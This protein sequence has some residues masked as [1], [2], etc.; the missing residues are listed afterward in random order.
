ME[1]KQ[2]LPAAKIEQESDEE[3]DIIDLDKYVPISEGVQEWDS[4]V[5]SHL[6]DVTAYGCERKLDS[7]MKWYIESLKNEASLL[8]AHS[9]V[10]SCIIKHLYTF[11]GCLLQL[12]Y[13]YVDNYLDNMEEI[14]TFYSNLELKLLPKWS[15]GKNVKQQINQMCRKLI[16]YIKLY[17]LC[18][19]DRALHV[20]MKMKV[21]IHSNECKSFMNHLYRAFLRREPKEKTDLAFCRAYILFQQWKRIKGRLN[22][23]SLDTLMYTMF[24]RRPED[25]QTNE[26]L[27]RVILHNSILDALAHIDDD[28]LIMVRK[29]FEMIHSENIQNINYLQPDFDELDEGI[30]VASAKTEDPGLEEYYINYRKSMNLV[31]QCSTGELKEENNSDDDCQF[32]RVLVPGDGPEIIHEIPDDDDDDIQDILMLKQ[33]IT[34]S[35]KLDEQNRLFSDGPVLG[36]KIARRIGEKEIDHSNS[37]KVNNNTQ[38]SLPKHKIDKHLNNLTPPSDDTHYENVAHLSK[39]AA[40]TAVI[41]SPDNRE[42]T[43]VGN[44]LTE[45]R[46]IMDTNSSVALQDISTIR[47]TSIS[48]GTVCENHC[49]SSK[50]KSDDCETGDPIHT[51]TP[52]TISHMFFNSSNTSE[53]LISSPSS[54]NLPNYTSNQDPYSSPNH[55]DISSTTFT[56][57]SEQCLETELSTRI[58]NLT[59]S[60][61]NFG[62][63]FT[64]GSPNLI[65][66]RADTTITYNVSD[67]KAVPVSDMTERVENKKLENSMVTQMPAQSA[68]DF[69]KTNSCKTWENLKDSH[70]LDNIMSGPVQK[71][72]S[73][74][75]PA[76]EGFDLFDDTG[77]MPNTDTQIA[78][79]DL[80][81][82]CEKRVDD[83]KAYFEEKST[84]EKNQKTILKKK[85]NLK[86]SD[87]LAAS[88]NKRVA[89]PEQSI[90]YKDNSMLS[91]IKETDK[92]L[93]EYPYVS[94][95]KLTQLQ[96]DQR[97]AIS[98][99]ARKLRLERERNQRLTIRNQ[100]LQNTMFKIDYDKSEVSLTPRDL[101]QL[102]NNLLGRDNLQAHNKSVEGLKTTHVNGNR[103]Q[104]GLKITHSVNGKRTKQCDSALTPAKRKRSTLTPAK[105]KKGTSAWLK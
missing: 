38:Q 96:I 21:D 34:E 13:C 48:D 32:V 54:S 72:V 50:E 27:K 31:P 91:M 8:H 92:K 105:R 101:E 35:Q 2:I 23:E 70:E 69:C 28:N 100:N 46:K 30:D 29:Y 75:A 89:F 18:R 51:S 3:E 81:T 68:S 52:A 16:Y 10:Q 102:Q 19:E 84:K 40:E 56:E 45:K 62:N 41:S 60:P 64:T 43:I 39:A 87:K 22:C 11:K 86:Q 73:E 66:D 9:L 1:S 90:I 20:L 77:N 104:H 59:K 74:S 6:Q 44:N 103:I 67:D 97:L 65:N 55:P 4:K 15:L 42:K 53:A 25:L 37:R 12:D 76:E 57:G 95:E 58:V 49:S 80:I 47:E 83:F 94:L 85:D 63:D 98:E 5:R 24:N 99:M 88:K 14:M 17:L 71:Y 7:I 82:P 93:Q 61:L 33:N 26:T 79:A 78:P 36:D